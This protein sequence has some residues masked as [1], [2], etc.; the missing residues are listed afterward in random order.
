LELKT[1][2]ILPKLTT[3][4]GSAAELLLLTL[5]M[6][7]STSC[8]PCT[9]PVHTV[10]HALDHNVL[11][12]SPGTVHMNLLLLIASPGIV[13]TSLPMLIAS[14]GIVCIGVPMLIASPGIGCVCLS[15]LNAPLGTVRSHATHNCRRDI[16]AGLK[17]LYMEH[18]MSQF[19]PPQTDSRVHVGYHEFCTLAMSTKDAP[20]CLLTKGF[21]P[22]GQA[23]QVPFACHLISLLLDGLP[24]PCTLAFK[25]PEH[26][27]ALRPMHCFIILSCRPTHKAYAAHLIQER[28]TCALC[29]LSRS[30][31]TWK[32]LSAFRSNVIVCQ[33]KSHCVEAAIYLDGM[34]AILSPVGPKASLNLLS[35]LAAKAELTVAGGLFPPE[36]LPEALPPRIWLVIMSGYTSSLY[37]ALAPAYNQQ[38]TLP[39]LMTVLYTQYSFTHNMRL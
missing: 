18:N 4:T 34:D 12:A 5:G 27:Q 17:Y 20:T 13:C 29:A 1:S 15:V 37:R 9:P 39:P 36:A 14:P 21:K 3:C 33:S 35:H 25:L 2:T 24:Q 8:S 23:R 11:I 38:T 28:T 10:L 22:M 6:C 32:H 30:M 16:L 31:T 19:K 26:C 7:G